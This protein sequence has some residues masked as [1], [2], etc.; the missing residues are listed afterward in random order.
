[1]IPLPTSARDPVASP[2]G[3]YVSL[4][5]RASS[6]EPALT[7]RIPP[8]PISTR[9]ALSNVSTRGPPPRRAP[10]RAPPKRGAV[11]CIGG[12]LARSRAMCTASA[13]L[14]PRSTPS[15]AAPARRRRRRAS[16]APGAPR[17][18][19]RGTRGS[20][21]GRAGCPRSRPG[22]AAPSSRPERR[23]LGGDPRVAVVARANA[24]AASRTA[25]LVRDAGS[26]TPTATSSGT[27]SPGSGIAWP[28][29]PVNPAAT[30]A[31]RLSPSSAGTSPDVET[32]TATAVASPGM[33]PATS[34]VRPA[35]ARRDGIGSKLAV[36]RVARSA[37]MVSFP[38]IV[39]GARL[40]VDPRC[41]GR[42]PAR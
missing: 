3:V 25:A 22:A 23:Q 27:A 36:G 33:D 5:R 19:D 26:P 32:G 9:A 41:R 20:G 30:S 11:R 21:S 7:P 12:V 16:R 38:L 10:G 14:R 6:A 24:A 8:Q 37:L 31:A 42:T 18:A 2:G 39:P 1:M 15:R 17:P 29:A 13:V 34:T 35:A 4:I 40:R 28:T